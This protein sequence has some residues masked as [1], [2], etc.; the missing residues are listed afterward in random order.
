[1]EN[2]L[3]D[4]EIK[5]DLETAIKIG[6]APIGEH[7]GCMISKL[8]AKEALDLINRL[9]AEKSNLTSNLTSLQN[10]LTSAKAEIERFAKL[11]KPTSTSGFKIEKDK[12]I[13]FTDM[14][15]GYKHEYNTLD[16]FIAECNLLLKRCYEVDDVN[17]IL[18]GKLETAKSEAVKE[19]AERFNKEAEDA[20][21]D[22]EDGFMFI[23]SDSD[24]TAKEI[25]YT[26]AE[27]CKE[28]ADNISKEMVG[29]QDA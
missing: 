12:V 22:N 25:Y 13:F 3:T 14:L 8:T 1:M 7:W 10:D 16:D 23:Y 17:S 15:N 28:V 9:E 24:N 6:D 26:L 4:N 5:K 20:W 11:T 18:K 19:F 2:K 21:I 27:W 29:E